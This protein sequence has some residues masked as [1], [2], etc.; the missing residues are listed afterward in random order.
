MVGGEAAGAEGVG[1]GALGAE[2]VAAGVPR[3]ADRWVLGARLEELGLQQRGQPRRRGALGVK[4]GHLLQA[5]HGCKLETSSRKMR[6][7]LQATSE[8]GE[9][10]RR[11]TRYLCLLL[12]R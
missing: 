11:I 12:L 9:E 5:N 7:E 1:A 8:R 4:T 3:R 10:K 6:T 2:E